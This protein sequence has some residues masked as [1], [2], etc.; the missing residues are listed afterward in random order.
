[1]GQLKEATV[2]CRLTEDEKAAL[3][4]IAERADIPLSKVVRDII[5]KYLKEDQN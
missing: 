4:K 3:V 1:M 2:S 5:K